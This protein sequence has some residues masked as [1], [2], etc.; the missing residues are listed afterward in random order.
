ME[1]ARLAPGILVAGKYA[2]VRPLGR[3]AMGEVWV[4]T[5]A[6]LGGELAIKFL[7]RSEE[8]AEDPEDASTALARFRFEAQIAARLSRRTRHIVSVTDHGTDRLGAPEADVPYLVMEL[9]EGESLEA[10]LARSGPL[11]LDE[12]API[13]A[14]I[15]KGLAHA[16]AEGFVHRDLKPANV[17]LGRDEDGALLVKILD[18]GIA[19]AARAHRVARG[20][21]T[22]DVGVVLGTP[23]YMSP[24]QA[25]GLPGLDQR[26]DL[27]ALATIAYEALTGAFP[28][29]GETTADLLVNIC[30]ARPIPARRLRPALPEA[31][32]AFFER[33]FAVRPEDR[34]ADARSFAEAFAALPGAQVPAAAFSLPRA[35]QRSSTDAALS[36]APRR[37]RVPRAGIVLGVTAATA[38]A[39]G[40]GLHLVR[41]G[42]VVAASSPI[43]SVTDHAVAREAPRSEAPVSPP[44]GSA[45]PVSASIARTDAAVEV[46]GTEPV[47]AQSAPRPPPARVPP[48][49][50]P[51]RTIDREPVRAVPKAP[52]PD[53]PG[54]PAKAEAPAVPSPRTPIDKGEIF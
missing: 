4:A 10:R 26:C 7:S 5:H 35:P 13:V 18:F 27:W 29:D 32:D 9:L 36:F 22:T 31:V 43:A 50:Q 40:A 41:R 17:L 48:S 24:E 20:Y 51:A 38:F 37:R 16:H 46:D 19:K 39:V 25:R 6:S 12:L 54:P 53:V 1:V 52:T 14:Q 3:G 49:P 45:P 34:F 21:G 2:L 8:H 42:P 23:T 47:R 44:P 11:D 28:Y 33:A 15:S 30:S